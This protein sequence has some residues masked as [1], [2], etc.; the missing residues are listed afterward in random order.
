MTIEIWYLI[1]FTGSCDSYR[2]SKTWFA[3]SGRVMPGILLVAGRS[4][5]GEQHGLSES[6]A[7]AYG[8]TGQ[9]NTVTLSAVGHTG[10]AG[11]QVWSG[12]N[13]YEAPHGCTGRA[14]QSASVPSAGTAGH[15]LSVKLSYSRDRP[16]LVQLS[17]EGP[18][19]GRRW[20][21]SQYQSVHL[22]C[23]GGDGGAGGRGENGQR[24]GQGSYGND[25]TQYRDATCG[26]RGARGGDGGRGSS[27]AS[28]GDA[29][30]A[31][32]TVAEDDLDTI[33]AVQWTTSGG[34]GGA[35]GVHGQ[36]GAGG[37]GGL[38][39]HGCSWT[40]THSRNVTEYNGN[41]Y[42]EYY[43]TYH[44]RAGA[45]PGPGGL[46]GMHPHEPL[47]GG[48]AGRNGHSQIRV[49]KN[50]LTEEVYTSRYQ[51]VVKGFDVVDE[52]MD[53]INEPGEFLKV[54]NI[55]VQN[56]GGMPSPKGNVLKIL[57]RSTPWLEPVAL[58]P[59]ELPR[60]ILPGATVSVHGVLKAFIKNETGKR[61]P[62][63]TFKV[64][65]TV[66]LVAFFE[67]LGRTLPEFSGRVDVS[68]QYPM[69][70]TAPKYLDCVAKG[71]MVQF[72]WTIANVSTKAYG[73]RSAMHRTCGTHLSDPCEVFDLKY[74]DE[75]SPHEISNAIDVLGPGSEVTVTEN[76]QVSQFVPVFITGY[77]NINLMLSDPQ[78]GKL[79]IITSFNL[80]IQISSAY[81]Y[82]PLS[83]FLLV[84][85]SSTPNKAILQ[86]MDFVNN[87][88]HLPLDIFNLSLV[89]SYKNLDADRT[90]LWNYIGKSIIIFGNTIDYF[91]CGTRDVWDLL[92]PW[93]AN[94]LARRGTGFLFVC[95]NSTSMSGIKA[96]AS[97]MAFAAFQ[98]ELLS[99]QS[100]KKAS[101]VIPQIKAGKQNPTDCILT[102]PVKK[103]MFRNLDETMESRAKS[104]TK[105]LK[106]R[107]PLR[108]F[109]VGP[110]DP[111]PDNSLPISKH[112]S[113]H[114][115][116][117]EGLP[118]HTK[119][120]VSLQPH[121]GGLADYM[122]AMIIHLL[123]FKDQCA[124][125]WNL[126]GY[127]HSM[128][129]SAQDAYRGNALGHLH[130]GIHDGMGEA[131]TLNTM[132]LISP[133]LGTQRTSPLAVASR[134]RSLHSLLA[135]ES[136]RLSKLLASTPSLRK[137]LLKAQCAS[138][139]AAKT[140]SEHIKAQHP[141]WNRVER[142]HALSCVHLET[143]TR[144]PTAQFLDLDAL[145][146]TRGS[147]C[148][149]SAQLT[150]RRAEH[151][152][153]LERLGRDE[154]WSRRKLKEMVNT[155]GMRGEE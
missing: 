50:D 67:R 32:I 56:V 51:L 39:G 130:A 97:Q 46:S 111:N 49:L 132:A 45:P 120:L 58:E 25:A 89:G 135:A 108:R 65:D 5:A 28:G 1:G 63:T 107:F 29:G 35:T 104:I 31:Y 121:T 84:I 122:I 38:G 114:V 71:D 154:A 148:L 74:A 92:D 143:L 6:G 47:Y 24:G 68:Y 23:R 30:S 109:I 94:M 69:V 90:V 87:G 100:A 105:E 136:A 53:G 70:M 98:P 153:S 128:G 72:S 134:A 118:H 125:F 115:A 144:T 149:S 10:I 129:I 151:A 77:I 96:W 152:R 91:Q 133:I 106:K 142:A 18:L 33:V 44:S 147:V 52:N 48:R 13:N 155:E 59:L 40:E 7:R 150:Q 54:Q 3:Q 11:T 73:S 99:T 37:L 41:S 86:T 12:N 102:L 95:P 26:G 141:A 113:G 62:G 60:D 139:A 16:G 101:E 36:P 112:K 124:F 20:E 4:N 116:I 137:Q 8:T 79:R 127:N 2:L 123:P 145:I 22:D 78:T 61:P 126:L 9:P 93:E 66:V 117:I 27:G 57:I 19:S 110:C 80:R 17:G 146:G 82:N 131:T 55:R 34:N 83:H 21:L 42:V 138:A 75:T 81:S 14:G 103:R 76:F 85:N 15:N 88:L 140:R 119:F 64:Y 43:N